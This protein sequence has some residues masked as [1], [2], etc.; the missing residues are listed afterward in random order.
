MPLPVV[1]VEETPSALIMLLPS[2][3]LIVTFEPVIVIVS[4][5]LPEFTCTPLADTVILSFPLPVLI[6][7]LSPATVTVLF[8]FPVFKD[9]FAPL[10]ETLLS[11]LLFKTILLLD[12]LDTIL[13]IP[14]LSVYEIESPFKTIEFIWAYNAVTFILL[15][16]KNIFWS[17]ILALKFVAFSI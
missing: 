10:I 7:E 4:S 3:E 12:P 8:P 13:E 6:V 1:T 11:L 2:P 17:C 9:E 15:P 16:F 5:P 14:M